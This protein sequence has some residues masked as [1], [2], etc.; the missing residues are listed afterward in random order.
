MSPARPSTSTE[1]PISPDTAI[2]EPGPAT[3]AAVA[4]RFAAWAAGLDA[5]AVPDAL[6]A[7]L[8]SLLV[9]QIGLCVAARRADYVG[10]V[11]ASGEAPGDCTAIGHERGCDAYDAA[12]VN[13][14]AGHGEDYDDTFE[15]TPVHAG[16]AVVPAVLAAAEAHGLAGADLLRGLA[17]GAELTCRLALVAPTAI[18]RAGFHPTAVLGTLGATAGVA[19]ALRLDPARF[20]AALGIAGSFAGGIIEYLAEGTW[21]KRVHA[22]WAAQAGIRAARMARHGFV[23]PR[24]VFEGENGVFKAFAIAG[25]VRDFAVLT[26]GLGDDWRAAA[27]AFKPYACGTMAQ[28]FIDCA[29]A[30]RGQGLDPD[31]VDSI[32]CRVGEGTVHRLWQ[33]RAEKINPSSAYSAKFSVPY[34]VAVG[35]VDGTAGLRQFAANRVADPA[36]RALAARV[37]YAIDPDDP[38]PADYRGHLRVTL[39]DG[40]VLEA[41]QP[42]LRGGRRAPLDRTEIAAKMRANLAHGGWPAERAEA[43]EA[44]CAGLFGAADMNGLRALRA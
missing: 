7:V 32:L 20:A 21:S 4:E 29:L 40:Q 12:L 23:G 28:P 26:E 6:R 27:I 30:L 44:L 18:H 5:G 42:H 16:A 22:G 11:L 33:P 41:E 34:C 17:V 10:A 39:R 15:G 3:D 19:A 25:I 2:A 38:Y 31:Q 36:L 35:L 14:T 43:V 13:G 37:D 9:D 8:E 1:A 24:T